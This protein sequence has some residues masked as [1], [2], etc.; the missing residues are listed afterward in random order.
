MGVMRFVIPLRKSFAETIAPRIYCAGMDA[1]PWR[2]KTQW[3]G[4]VLELVR[5]ATATLNTSLAEILGIT[6]KLGSGYHRD[7]Q[8]LKSPLFRAIDLAAESVDIMA[9]L[10]DGLEFQPGNIKLDDGIFATAEAYRLVR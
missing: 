3:A 6:T 9:Y 4:D 8:R 5:G 10:L 7:L 2:S 1:V